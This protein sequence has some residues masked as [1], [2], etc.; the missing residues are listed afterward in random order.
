MFNIIDIKILKT[1]SLIPRKREGEKQKKQN[2]Q[3]SKNIF[4]RK[5]SGVD[6]FGKCFDYLLGGKGDYETSL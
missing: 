2:K 4:K 1:V 6:F 5:M 3:A